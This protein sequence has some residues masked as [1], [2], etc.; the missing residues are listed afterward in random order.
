MEEKVKNC[1]QIFSENGNFN[2][3]I[4][5]KIK[6]ENFNSQVNKI[7]KLFNPK[8]VNCLAHDLET[9]EF[10]TFKLKDKIL[11]D[12]KIRQVI[13]SHKT[14]DIILNCY[15]NKTTV[16][17]N[18][19]KPSQHNIG[20]EIV[21]YYIKTRNNLYLVC[22]FE[23]DIFVDSFEESINKIK[24]DKSFH[25]VILIEKENENIH[26]INKLNNNF[27]IGRLKY[28]YMHKYITELGL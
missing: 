22:G 11:D 20:N 9:D 18:I 23:I 26:R 19:R 12:E 13:F 16:C 6:I 7:I 27:K 21:K 4:Y 14:E 24:S 2:C 5:F 17:H 15:K 1:N 25:P 10:D 8:E 28:V 3:E